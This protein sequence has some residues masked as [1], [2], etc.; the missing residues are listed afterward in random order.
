GDQHRDGAV[1]SSG[2]HRRLYRAALVLRR[3]LPPRTARPLPVV[4]GYVGCFPPG[5]FA[6]V[7]TPVSVPIQ[8]A[9]NAAVAAFKEFIKALANGKL[10][11]NGAYPA[12]GVRYDIDPA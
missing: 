4:P 11:A 3:G 6:S 7:I 12:T 5:P 10:I 9:W 8:R 1:P 2:R